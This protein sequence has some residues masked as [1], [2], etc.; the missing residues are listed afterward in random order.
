MIFRCTSLMALAFALLLCSTSTASPV[1]SVLSFDEADGLN[2]T[3]PIGTDLTPG[4]L[5]DTG[6]SQF[7]IDGFR[8][9]VTGATFIYAQN[10]FVAWASPNDDMS[11]ATVND[12]TALG[13]VGTTGG[14]T[15]EFTL[16]PL[17]PGA[18]FDL[19]S[20]SL[21]GFNTNSNPITGLPVSVQFTGTKS[22][23]STV[24]FNSGN[25]GPSNDYTKDTI[26]F[27]PDFTDLTSVTWS[28]GA[29]F[30]QHQF[31]DVR[32]TLTAVAVPEPTTNVFL[33]ACLGLVW[34]RVRRGRG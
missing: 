34:T 28:Q 5:V 6:V 20:M 31:D 17:Q 26:T 18:T 7:D 15:I 21:A 11:T 14:S 10:Q 19:T 12:S 22:D 3:V 1:T 32:V 33:L 30:R 25:I 13:T 23:S 29:Q 16:T 8:F 2:V 27:T 4:R 24:N 9:S